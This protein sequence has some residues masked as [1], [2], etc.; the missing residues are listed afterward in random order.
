MSDKQ[1]PPVVGWEF[2]QYPGFSEWMDDYFADG[3]AL[4]LLE[5]AILLDPERGD[6]I[7]DCGGVRKMR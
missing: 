5:N 4:R 2:V 7:R 6:V 3:E 1:P